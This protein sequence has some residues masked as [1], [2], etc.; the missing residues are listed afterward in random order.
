MM[1]QIY[2]LN[3]LSSMAVLLKVHSI[4]SASPQTICYH[5]EI[6][7]QIRIGIAELL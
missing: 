3:L 5:S 7:T 2:I 4:G 1:H 6:S